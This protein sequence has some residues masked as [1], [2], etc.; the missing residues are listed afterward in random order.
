MDEDGCCWGNGRCCGGGRLGGGGGGRLGC[1][2]TLGSFT[3][4]VAGLGG[5]LLGAGDCP[6]EPAPI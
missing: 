3:L 6:S 1:D 5:G 4:G 2:T